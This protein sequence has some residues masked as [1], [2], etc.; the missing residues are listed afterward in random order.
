MI[1]RNNFFNYK[2]KGVFKNKKVFDVEHTPEYIEHRDNQFQ[3]L[4]YNV[5]SILYDST[6][7]N[8]VL[9][10]KYATGKTTVARLF[11]EEAEKEFDNLY[12]VMVNCQFYNTE[13]KILLQIYNKLYDTSIQSGMSTSKLIDKIKEKIEDKYL[14]VCL[15]EFQNIKNT[16]ELNSILYTLSRSHEY[17]YNLHITTYCIT[18]ADTSWQLVLSDNVCTIF[19]PTAVNFPQYSESEIYDILMRRVELGFYP[20]VIDNYDF[21]EIV[22]ST[23][24]R[25]NLRF[26]LNEL[27]KYGVKKEM[28]LDSYK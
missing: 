4:A 5:N 12:T 6:P 7:S 28:E 25:G 10:G 19:L 18:T 2:N 13:N 1:N 24:L 15:D 21:E 22:E 11:L 23:Y 27:K 14:I 20:N 16:K 8:L 3:A 17:R 26:G 9:Q